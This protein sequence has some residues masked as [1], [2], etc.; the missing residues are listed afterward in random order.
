MLVLGPSSPVPGLGNEVPGPS[1]DQRPRRTRGH[2]E[3][4]EMLLDGGPEVNAQ[5]AKFDNALQAA[6]KRGHEKV[7][8]MLLDAGAEDHQGSTEGSEESD[9]ARAL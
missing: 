6:S 9:G 3:V 2:E 7:V 8:Q 5:G 1:K 4:V